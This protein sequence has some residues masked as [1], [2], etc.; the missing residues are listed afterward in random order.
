MGVCNNRTPST[1]LSGRSVSSCCL[2]LLIFRV[3]LGECSVYGITPNLVCPSS[4]PSFPVPSFFSHWEFVLLWEIS[5]KYFPHKVCLCVRPI[6]GSRRKS[7]RTETERILSK[8]HNT[9]ACVIQLPLDSDICFNKW[10]SACFQ[11]LVPV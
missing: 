4:P 8:V 9:W 5:F 7:G 6:Q 11:P 3:I 10:T 1:V 2:N